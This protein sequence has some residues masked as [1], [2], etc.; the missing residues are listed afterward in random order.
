MKKLIF[1][2]LF[3]MSLFLTSCGADYPDHDFSVVSS[4]ENVKHEVSS[5]DPCCLGYWHFVTTDFDEGEIVLKCTN[6]DKVYFN[7]DRITPSKSWKDE[8]ICVSADIIDNSSIRIH[9]DALPEDSDEYAMYSAGVLIYSKSKNDQVKSTIE[10]YR[11][12]AK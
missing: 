5:L 1:N 4:S 12:P 7:G 2:L 10:F 11:Y 6:F 3:L 8:R 9:F